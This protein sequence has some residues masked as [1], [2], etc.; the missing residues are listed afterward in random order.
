M[1]E[2]S[3]IINTN[4]SDDSL[5]LV[6]TEKTL[7]KLIT[8]AQQI[9]DMVK[10]SLPKYD[11]TNY[12]DDNIEQ[13]KK[14]KAAL[15]KAAKALNDKRIELEGEFNKPF[16]EFKAVISDTVILIKQCSSKIDEVVKDN[17]NKRIEKKNK[18]IRT[19]FDSMQSPVTL[20]KIFDQRWL[21]KTVTMH[22][23]EEEIN[24]KITDINTNLEYLKNLA[25]DDE[26]IYESLKAQFL[27][28][29]DLNQ[30]LD[31]FNQVKKQREEAEAKKKSEEAAA[32]RNASILQPES[33][34]VTEQTSLF[35]Q[36]SPN[37]V[38]EQPSNVIEHPENVTG[39]ANFVTQPAVG[40][41][42]ILTRYFTV[43]CS[44]SKL[45][46][47][48]DYLNDNDIDFDKIEIE[49]TLCKSDRKVI[50]SLL[51]FSSKYISEHS[52]STSDTN[53]CRIMNNF[54]KKLSKMD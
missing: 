12:N 54:M 7:G 45:I 23:V 1:D 14:D 25:N 24:K 43:T 52:T 11:V 38:T 8:N 53:K 31:Y 33:K 21:N 2:K 34:P 20:D 9:H 47:L 28:T 16:L 5:E 19:L 6:V 35:E 48:S 50:Q 30:T 32:A 13:A 46:A 51:E 4:L 17:D 41:E 29:L 27:V 40:E 42:G 26:S 10:E 39:Q 44:T 18:D 37:S 36:K 3:S 49:D 15:N 22:K